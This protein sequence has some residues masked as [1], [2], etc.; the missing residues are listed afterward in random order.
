MYNLFVHSLANAQKR[1]SNFSSDYLIRA[2][3]RGVRV[4][5][6]FRQFSRKLG[7][8]ILTM[9]YLFHFC[10]NSLHFC[11][12]FDFY[13]WYRVV[14]TV[15]KMRVC[16]RISIICRLSFPS[17]AIFFQSKG[18][19]T[20]GVLHRFHSKILKS[21]LTVERKFNYMA[22]EKWPLTIYNMNSSFL[23]FQNLGL[24]KS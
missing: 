3:Q 17:V 5:H 9:V 4:S 23:V 22:C 10:F 7:K 2:T 11:C 1:R 18:G 13:I 12:C 8:S 24:K 20:R 16:N 19:G 6:I 21:S 14:V 15:W